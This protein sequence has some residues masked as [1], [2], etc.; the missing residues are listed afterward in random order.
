M[1]A[2]IY[3]PYWDTLG[4]G[5]RYCASV[6]KL[7]LSEGFKVDI[8][9]NNKEIIEKLQKRFSLAIK[10]ANVVDSVYRGDGYDLCFWISDGSIP[11]LKSRNNLLHFQVPFKKVNGKTLINRMKLLRVKHILC[12]SEFTKSFIDNEFGVI[13]EV[14][15]PPV[16][17]NRFKP[18][19]KENLILY[20]G[21]F[22]QLTQ[23]KNQH[24][25]VE[26]FKKFYERNRKWKLVVAGGVEVGVNEYVKK[27]KVAA[28]GYPISIVE[29][30]AFASL[31]ELNGKS[32][33]YWSASGYGVDEK[34]NP[35][36]VE[37]FG[38]SLVEAM[39]AGAVPV[40]AD[41]GGHRE[42]VEEK[43][44]GLLWTKK[45]ELIDSTEKLISDTKL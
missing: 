14:L 25:L 40:V 5:E 13:S 37:H 1:K 3:N 43:V 17:V 45:E 44:S 4:G 20:V 39:A 2:A 36:K 33:I 26:M 42:I 24:I 12:N 19:R 29:S 30:P 34:N 27:L 38:I 9:W 32:K 16:D 28:K 6:V 41:A 15:Y 10:K 35:Q 23:S 21:R 8:E 31:I 22:S 11:T 18:K 7:L